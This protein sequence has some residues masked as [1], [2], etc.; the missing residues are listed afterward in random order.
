MRCALPA[1]G[2]A[3]G[4]QLAHWEMILL[5]VTGP[6]SKSCRA[7]CFKADLHCFSVLQNAQLEQE[8]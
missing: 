2:S 6:K 5:D 1:H 7:N 8:E 4:K 3:E